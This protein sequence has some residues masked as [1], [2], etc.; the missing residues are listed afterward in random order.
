MLRKSTAKKK[1]CFF[2]LFITGQSPREIHEA[3]P[4]IL[5]AQSGNPRF[6]LGDFPVKYYCPLTLAMGSHALL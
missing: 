1:Y 5:R 3:D 6:E 2:I 4:R